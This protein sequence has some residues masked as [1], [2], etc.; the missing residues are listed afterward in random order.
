MKTIFK[1]WFVFLFIILGLHAEMRTWTDALGRTLI[2]RP[3]SKTAEVITVERADGKRFDLTLTDL[4]DADRAWVKNWSPVVFHISQHGPQ[5]K[6]KTTWFVVTGP[7]YYNLYFQP[8]DLP[9]VITALKEFKRLAALSQ[10]EGVTGDL[11]KT[12]LSRPWGGSIEPQPVLTLTV[13]KK[14]VLRGEW[15][16]GGD[17]TPEQVTYLIDYLEA[18]SPDKFDAELRRMQAA[19]R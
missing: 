14:P 13:D 19:V 12:L 2:A 1:L 18:F 3:V 5:V 6:N 15:V 11:T 9:D 17:Y 16:K 8:Q 4:V 10:A 7:T